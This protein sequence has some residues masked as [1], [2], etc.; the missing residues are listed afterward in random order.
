[1]EAMYTILIIRAVIWC[2]YHFTAA[3]QP[4]LCVVVVVAVAVVVEPPGRGGQIEGG[5]V[6]RGRGEVV[7]VHQRV[8]VTYEAVRVQ[9]SSLC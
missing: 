9:Y 4:V 7:L 8:C 1:M 5:R 3:G 6:L 2:Q